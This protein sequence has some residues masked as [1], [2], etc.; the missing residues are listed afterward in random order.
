MCVDHQLCSANWHQWMCGLASKGSSHARAAAGRTQWSAYTDEAYSLSSRCVRWTLLAPTS[1]TL[2]GG[3][4][5]CLNAELRVA[6]HCH[7]LCITA[8]GRQDNSATMEGQAAILRAAGRNK[9]ST[10]CCYSP[11]LG[12]CTV[13][14]T[15][16]N[17][18]FALC[19]CGWSALCLA[20]CS[21]L[22]R[23]CCRCC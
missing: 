1:H 6:Y 22:R 21:A 19:A 16:C 15:S 14:C 2:G 11:W 5:S 3:C 13:I 7:P 4:A 23:C 12:S 10:Y 8:G 17:T 18:E 9:P 20:A